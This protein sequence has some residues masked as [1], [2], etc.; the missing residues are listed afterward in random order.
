MNLYLS[1][2]LTFFKVGAFTLGGGYAMIPL[3]EREV[4]DKKKWLNRQEFI[5]QIAV[6]QSVP[7]VFA[8]NMAI[9]VGYKLRGVKGSIATT[10]GTILPSFIIILLIALF[11]F[12]FKDNEW[13]IKIFKGIRP[14]VVALIA[15]PVLTTAR[16]AG[17]TY[18][19]VMIPIVTALLI[20]LLNVSPVYIVI[21]AALAGVLWQRHKAPKGGKKSITKQG[22]GSRVPLRDKTLSFWGLAVPL[23]L[24]GLGKLFFSFFKIGL[25]GF[26]GGYA[27]L[28][29]IQHEVVESHGWL[30]SAEFTDLVAISQMTPGPIGINTATFVGYTAGGILGSAVA[31]IALVLPSFAIMLT[32]CKLFERFRA[33]S[34]IE[35]AFRA[36]RLVVV[37]L[38]ASAALML[39]T[40]D[41]FVDYTS[42]IILVVAF[43]ATWK[44]KLNPI[45][46][47]IAAG[48]FGVFFY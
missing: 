5:D 29:L 23:P 16:T 43:F 34:Y 7:G 40:P 11:F 30:T 31:T 44:F 26:G 45:L 47:I 20:W 28:S 10:L 33:N 48:V 18:K 9:F 13:V 1:S 38:I 22:K 32:I 4:V 15:I 41:N 36:L 19:T 25:F 42:V 24:W 39:L 37:G 46:T 8:V 35:A 17:I 6:A 14:A 21:V 12:S 27:M 3:I 2:F